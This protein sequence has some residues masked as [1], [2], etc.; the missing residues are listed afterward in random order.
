[1]TRLSKAPL[2]LLLLL[3]GCPDL[4]PSKISATCT[5]AFDKCKLADGPLGVCQEIECKAGED[6]PCLKCV[7]QH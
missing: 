4:E 5:K 1:M 2:L 3:C 7:S 6:K